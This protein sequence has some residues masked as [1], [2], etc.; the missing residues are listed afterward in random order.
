MLSLSLLVELCPNTTEEEGSI[1]GLDGFIANYR[2][3]VTAVDFHTV[4]KLHILL[5]YVKRNKMVKNLIQSQGRLPGV[6][7]FSRVLNMLAL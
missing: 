6:F 5:T 4:F 7:V 2:Q 1:T 3:S